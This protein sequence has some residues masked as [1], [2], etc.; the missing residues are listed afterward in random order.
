MLVGSKS[1]YT[2]ISVDTTK[3]SMV[4]VQVSIT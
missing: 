4:L 3:K 2:I 1:E